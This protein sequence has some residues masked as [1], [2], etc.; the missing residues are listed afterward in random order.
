[1]GGF[2]MADEKGG[3]KMATNWE[4]ILGPGEWRYKNGHRIYVRQPKGEK[5]EV[6][7][8]KRTSNYLQ[9]ALK[10]KYGGIDHNGY[11]VTDDSATFFD[12]H[13]RKGSVVRDMAVGN[14][15]K[16]DKKHIPEYKEARQIANST[17]RRVHLVAEEKGKKRPDLMI[18]TDN[19]AEYF[20]R[21]RYSSSGT[22]DRRLREGSEQIRRDRRAKTGGQ[23]FRWHRVLRGRFFA[24]LRARAFPA[25]MRRHEAC[26][27]GRGEVDRRLEGR[28][29]AFAAEDEPDAERDGN[30]FARGNPEERTQR[31]RG[32]AGGELD[33]EVALARRRGHALKRVAEGFEETVCGAVGFHVLPGMSMMERD[34][35]WR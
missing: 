29:G 6:A 1:M 18:E 3:K 28:V 2:L 16:L 23:S 14:P 19:R 32:G 7:P 17:G 11:N 35:I 8:R 15:W 30:P 31:D 26:P 20:E 5:R 25:S 22:F 34:G 24:P 12:N 9:E 10:E 4:E 33:A 21:K 27:G 13:G